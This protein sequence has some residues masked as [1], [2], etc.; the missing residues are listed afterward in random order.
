MTETIPRPRGDAADPGPV[1]DA[2]RPD[3]LL[4][5]APLRIEA[6]AVRQGLGR[7]GVTHPA[8]VL[9]TGYGTTRA[10]QA[11]GELNQR[12]FG[13]M[14]IMGVGAGL[15][16]DLRPGDLVVGTEVGAVS[17]ASAPLLAAELAR[18]GLR[19]QAGRSLRWT[20]WSG[21]TNAPRWPRGAC[22]PPTWS[23]RRWPPRRE[24]ARWP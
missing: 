22:W 1:S 15:T 7:G 2:T 4:I 14:V 18:A 5:C 9:H 13:Q 3:P 10:V 23:R 12:P 19:A 17:C 21:G 16:A 8:R 11:A 20:T 6:R 24:A